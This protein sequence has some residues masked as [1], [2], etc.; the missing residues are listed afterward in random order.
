MD[1]IQKLL[2][3]YGKV[4]SGEEYTSSDKHVVS[5]IAERAL[6]L[7]RT[8]NMKEEQY[9]LFFTIVSTT[10]RSKLERYLAAF[11]IPY[12][13]E[14]EKRVHHMIDLHA[15]LPQTAAE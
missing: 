12:K 6:K 9:F 13:M 10:F 11:L 15:K 7:Y 8:P 14:T 4:V 2:Q 1:A 3:L 5:I